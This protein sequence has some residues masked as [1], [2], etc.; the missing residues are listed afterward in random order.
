MKTTKVKI[1]NV[2][3]YYGGIRKRTTK[4]LIEL[5]QYNL[6]RD[7]IEQTRIILWTLG[8]SWQEAEQIIGS[9]LD[10]K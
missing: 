2:I 6:E 8:F 4:E 9:I 10:V 7:R 5:I 3:R 1:N